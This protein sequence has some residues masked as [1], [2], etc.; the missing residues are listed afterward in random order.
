MLQAGL[1]QNNVARQYGNTRDRQPSGRTRV[2]SRQQDN[3]IRLVHQ[4]RSIPDVKSHCR[5]HPGL[6]PIS[7][8]TVRNRHRHIRALRPAIRPILLLSYHT[9]ILTWC[10]CHLR[11][12]RQDWTNILFTDVSRFHIDSSDGRS[13][14]QRRSFGR[15]SVMVW[16]GIT[17]RGSTPLVVVTENL[18]G[19]R[20]WDEFFSAMLFRSSKFRSTMSHSSRTAKPHVARV[21]GDYLILQNV[22]VLQ[23]QVVSPIFQP[24]STSGMKWNDGCVI[25]KI[26][27]WR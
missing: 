26:N 17:E 22:D 4:L 13:G 5:K 12:R 7:F 8:R 2:T 21:V 15:G 3:P 1:A 9:T 20:L 25:C 24:L 16:E 23:W 11:F 27:Q 19:I 6:R 14:I 10:R 18:T